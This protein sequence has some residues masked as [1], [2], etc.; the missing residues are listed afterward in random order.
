M[1]FSLFYNRLKTI[2][3]FKLIILGVCL[4]VFLSPSGSSAD[5][6]IAGG[7]NDAAT[8]AV[9]FLWIAALLM[10]AKISSLIERI[11]QP[12][13]LGELLIGVAI[14]SLPLIGTHFFEPIK[15]SGVIHFLAELGVVILLFQIGMESSVQTMM[16]VGVP[17]FLV[18]CVGVILPFVATTY[19]IG[20][21]LA[22]GLPSTAYL[23]LG[24]TLTATSVGITARVLKDINKST[25]TEARTIIGAAVI[26][27][28][29][30]LIILAVVSAIVLE[31]SIDA[32]KLSIILI[33]AIVFLVGGLFLGTW[34]APRLS[35]VFSKIHTGVGMK[36]ALVISFG[37]VF[38]YLASVVGLAP[39]VGAFT[40]GLILTPVYF[41]QFSNPPFV[42]D[43]LGAV[44]EE[45]LSAGFREKLDSIIENHS[46][47][48]IEE[49]AAHLGHF[50]I[51]IFFVLTGM[52]VKIDTLFD[53]NVLFMTLGIFIV[54]VV[55][56]VLAGYVA[57]KS[58]NRLAVGIGM[59]PRGEVGLI[60]ANM[61]KSLGV[62][63]DTVFSAMV[64]VIMATTL[65]TPPMLAV[66]FKKIR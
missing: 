36:F 29:L 53:L 35:L 50:L 6:A 15:S 11:G 13:V 8:V 65:I 18:A 60:F 3:A 47:K 37:L 31:G 26:D 44:N 12:A 33:K 43:I 45:P 56:K 51:P 14:G 48:H 10:L 1:S 54:A 5:D 17:S 23:F 66:V 62:M 27:D 25:T 34:L 63:N 24:A 46:H 41:K 7:S 19:F 59:V 16:K 61:G 39:I 58:M 9:T 20:P 64:V 22:P 32:T 40:A 57:G 4:A 38:S 42:E 49:F 52:Q 28:V 21:L 30:G 2:P 55:T